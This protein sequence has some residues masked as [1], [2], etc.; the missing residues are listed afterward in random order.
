MSD[1]DLSVRFEPSTLAHHCGND[2]HLVK[3]VIQEFLRIGPGLVDQIEIANN[4]DA[5]HSLKSSSRMIGAIRLGELCE[6]LERSQPEESP[7][8]PTVRGEFDLLAR[9]LHSYL[10]R[11]PA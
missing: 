1:P 3:R 6:Q 8:K 4:L 2:A 11:T 7:S 10:E 9:E 5:A